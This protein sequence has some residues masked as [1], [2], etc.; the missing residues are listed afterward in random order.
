MVEQRFRKPQVRG[1]YPRIGSS[2]RHEAA[3]EGYRRR[4]LVGSLPRGSYAR[5]GMNEARQPIGSRVRHPSATHCTGGIGRN[6][7]ATLSGDS[8]IICPPEACLARIPGS[9]S[10]HLAGLADFGQTPHTSLDR[11][12]SK[13]LA[14]VAEQL[15]WPESV[16]I[17]SP[18]GVAA[19]ILAETAQRKLGRALIDLHSTAVGVRIGV[20]AGDP[21]SDA[22]DAPLAIVCV[23]E[24]T[25]SETVLQDL[26]TLA[27][28]FARSPLLITL[29]P[30]RLRSWSCFEAPRRSA[31]G[32]RDSRHAE[33]CDASGTLSRNGIL[34]AEAAKALDWV[35]LA[36]GE[37]FRTHE[38]HFPRDCRADRTLLDNLRCVRRRLV[39]PD[40]PSDALD[41]DVAHDLLA[42]LIFIQFLFQRRDSSGTPALTPAVLGRLHGEGKLRHEYSALHEVLRSHK[43]SYALFRWLNSIF[44]GD[45]FPAKSEIESERE[46]EWEAEERTVRARHL[47]LLADFVG[48]SLVLANGQL[49]LW[50]LYSFDVIPLE[51]ISSVYEEFVHHGNDSDITTTHYTPLH[52]VDFVLD[53]VLPWDSD[54]WDLKILDPS[55]GSG[56]FLV[57][58]YQRLVHRWKRAHARTRVPTEVL[59]RLLEENLVGIDIDPHAVRVASF[60]LYLAM[61]DEIDPR[62]YWKRVRFPVLRGQRL[63]ADDFF[64]DDHEGIHS[65]KSEGTF[66]LIIG[67]APWGKK[68]A[69]GNA[70]EWASKHGWPLFNLDIGPL[71]L[72]RALQLARP[73]APVALLQPAGL[74][75]NHFGR[76]FRRQLFETYKVDEVVNLSAL[77]R[78]LFS[79]SASPS[80]LIILR[81]APPD[82]EPLRYVCPKPTRTGEDQFRIVIDAHDINDIYP[83]EAANDPMA[84]TV[85]IWGGRRD[86][87]F[88]HE[89]R[90]LPTLARLVG[91]GKARAGVGLEWGN[92]RATLGNIRPR[93]L[94]DKPKLPAGTF[95]NLD[96][97]SLRE[98][99]EIR[100]DSTRVAD[101]RVFDTPQL[102]IKR[103]WAAGEER[104][105]AALV[106]RGA[107]E[108][109]DG[110]LCTQSY[111]SISTPRE[112]QAGLAAAFL[113][114]SSG[115]A[116]YY[117]LM[118]SGRMASYRPEALLGE[119][120]N[121][122][123]PPIQTTA[124]A[125]EILEGLNT[126]TDVN[127]RARSAYNFP[128]AH[129]ALIDDVVKY[130][131]PNFKEDGRAP[132][133]RPTQRQADKN[134]NG[135]PELREYC[136]FFIRVLQAT[137]ATRDVCATIYQDA[138]GDALPVRLVAIHFDWP[139]DRESVQICPSLEYDLRTRL[140][141][142]DA[143][144][145]K[146]G[147]HRGGSVFYQRVAMVYSIGRV[148][149]RKIPSIFLVK[150]DRAR[151]WT[152]SAAMRDA[153]EVV[154]ESG[155]WESHTGHATAEPTLE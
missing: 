140:M 132:G 111:V 19:G 128:P 90:R 78:Q 64:H 89:L 3:V 98:H 82:G 55:C 49:S 17:L 137:F 118:T 25:V 33:I 57:K 14:C 131:L 84:W 44:N 75:L 94:L 59:R 51:F 71:F 130:T 144:L 27:W 54:E 151:Y 72:A 81:N 93:R 143:Q 115:F 112:H 119:F 133:W 56:I 108:A 30:T 31:D 117:S 69:S 41:P 26:H 1:S 121:M 36:S 97:T 13:L 116:V 87:A 6:D 129:Q 91:A 5:I 120:L 85:F 80:C 9:P 65:S 147:A 153:D 95:I 102:L 2:F 103:S 73:D 77:R 10:P 154:T 96:V 46:R 107:P 18:D 39:D 23:F 105:S 4:S 68:S 150:P 145:L 149:R 104:F 139:G 12:M 148:G 8:Q 53:A 141:A 29:E 60:S 146:E 16:R 99:A 125:G 126:W 136:N 43:D 114:F 48:G 38:Q 28:N 113:A 35:N 123:L 92:K 122:P 79:K 134:H 22:T 67:N 42:R 155:I 50:P 40:D 101:L 66:D 86:Y 62:D 47:Q 142:L 7:W 127:D 106:L 61:C 76:D 110:V 100:V 45:L 11:T 58:A 63:I 74:L 109:E 70:R 138:E 152:R 20:L 15:G 52:L 135:E 34:A 37:F 32:H 21:A 24:H 88:V 83:E 124:A